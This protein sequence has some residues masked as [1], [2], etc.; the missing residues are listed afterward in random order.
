MCSPAPSPTLDSSRWSSLRI[1]ILPPAKGRTILAFHFPVQGFSFFAD[2]CSPIHPDRC[3]IAS[4]PFWYIASDPA[5][6]NKEPAPGM[7]LPRQRSDTGD[8]FKGASLGLLSAET[9]AGRHIHTHSLQCSLQ[10]CGY[11][12]GSGSESINGTT[13]SIA[14]TGHPDTGQY[15]WWR[16]FFCCSRAASPAS[17]SVSC[18]GTG[19]CWRN[20]LYKRKIFRASAANWDML[21][22]GINHGRPEYISKHSVSGQGKDQIPKHLTGL[23]GV[24]AICWKVSVI[25]GVSPSLRC[26]L[27]RHAIV[28][29]RAHWN[30]SLAAQKTLDQ[31][32]LVE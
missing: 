14:V 24:R 9:E 5:T 32:Q 31:Q 16:F 2:K 21:H 11:R 12:L 8:Y 26:S 20:N 29:W 28:H 17:H 4:L 30:I 6:C 22:C 23:G 27:E 10:E 18:D 19:Q 25:H 15:P 3:H 1:Y 13:Q 7:P